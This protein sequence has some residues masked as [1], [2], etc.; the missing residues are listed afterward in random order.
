MQNLPQLV[1][2]KGRANQHVIPRDSMAKNT[3]SEA[4][5]TPIVGFKIR[6]SL[7][8]VVVERVSLISSH[9]VFI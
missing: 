9:Q 8:F 7:R 5:L 4:Q 6:K 1:Q 2:L 3:I